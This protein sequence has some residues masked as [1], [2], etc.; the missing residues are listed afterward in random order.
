MWRNTCLPA[1]LTISQ[2]YGYLEIATQLLQSIADAHDPVIHETEELLSWLNWTLPFLNNTVKSYC[3]CEGSGQCS[4]FGT[5]IQLSGDAEFNEYC[6]LNIIMTSVEQMKV[7]MTDKSCNVQQD[8]QCT[9]ASPTVIQTVE[10]FKQQLQQQFQTIASVPPA[11]ACFNEVLMSCSPPPDAGQDNSTLYQGLCTSLNIFNATT[12]SP[13]VVDLFTQLNTTILPLLQ[14]HFEL[15]VG[16][17]HGEITNN[18]DFDT[19][20][21]ED[22]PRMLCS[23]FMVNNNLLHLLKMDGESFGFTEHRTVECGQDAV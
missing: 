16:C 14:D 3:S 5:E 17:S 20:V 10:E 23:L 11:L 22:N 2:S 1:P 9:R 21:P 4:G 18:L 13:E 6:A 7:E 15:T 19:C 12:A 8:L